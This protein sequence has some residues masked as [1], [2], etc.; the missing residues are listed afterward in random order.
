LAGKANPPKV[1]PDGPDEE[2]PP[3][4]GV[5]VNT[6]NE[7]AIGAGQN[8]DNHTESMAG[9]KHFVRQMTREVP[10]FRTKQAAFRYAAYLVTLAENTLPD[11]EGAHTYEEIL[12]A[13]QNA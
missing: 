8:M 10:A 2:T 7:W 3:R 4:V 1:V 6:L 5:P 13:I 12:H 11:E 9:R